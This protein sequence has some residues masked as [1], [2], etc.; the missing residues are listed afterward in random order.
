MDADDDLASHR[1]SMLQ[2][3]DEQISNGNFPD[4][5]H[6]FGGPDEM[7]WGEVSEDKMLN[8]Q[9]GGFT[10]N[11]TDESRTEVSIAADVTNSVQTVGDAVLSANNY[12]NALRDAVS[13]TRSLSSD[14][15]Q[16]WETGPVSFLFSKSAS[17]ELDLSL[18]NAQPSRSS[19][20]SKGEGSAEVVSLTTKKRRLVSERAPKFLHCVKAIPDCGYIEKRAANRTLAICKISKIRS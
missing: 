18:K 10:P 11:F 9:E 2:Q 1:I 15:K 6:D 12:S 20:D 4:G 3:F 16:P 5:F 19:M 8:F 7:S 13:T 17:L 14:L